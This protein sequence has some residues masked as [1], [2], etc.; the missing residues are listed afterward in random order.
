MPHFVLIYNKVSVLS[1][2]DA[3]F[4]G[5][6]YT[7]VLVLCDCGLQSPQCLPGLVMQVAT[8]VSPRFMQMHE[9]TY[10]GVC[11]CWRHAA[12]G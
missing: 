4:L 8:N 7:S 5:A 10:D 3:L 11:R 2:P 1:A 6:V 9:R 12:R